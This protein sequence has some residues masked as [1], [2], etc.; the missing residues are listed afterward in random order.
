MPVCAAHPVYL[1]FC[2]QRLD[3]LGTFSP[4]LAHLGLWCVMELFSYVFLHVFAWGLSRPVQI[5]YH[6]VLKTSLAMK[7]YRNLFKRWRELLKS[8]YQIHLESL[9]GTQQ[10]RAILQAVHSGYGQFCRQHITATPS[11]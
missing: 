4:C 7:L 5:R 9:G 1:R 2:E 3:A 11:T 6:E 10:L 8:L